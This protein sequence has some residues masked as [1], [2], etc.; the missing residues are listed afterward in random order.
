MNEFMKFVAH[1]HVP[2]P[3][4]IQRWRSGEEDRILIFVIIGN[5]QNL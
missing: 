1:C 5:H 4:A 3:K 2:E